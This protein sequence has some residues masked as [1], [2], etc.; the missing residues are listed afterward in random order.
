MSDHELQTLIVTK[1]SELA[2]GQAEIA[3]D[4]DAVKCTWRS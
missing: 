2:V 1:L 3:T 4:M